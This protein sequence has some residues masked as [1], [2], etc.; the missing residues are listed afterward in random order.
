MATEEDTFM[1]MDSN[2]EDEQDQGSVQA[3]DDEK[4][5]M[6]FLLN[7]FA[8]TSMG[9]IVRCARRVPGLLV[10]AASISNE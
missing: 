9:C 7:G 1:R 2:S 6:H 10:C 4:K 3:S 5:L 8:L